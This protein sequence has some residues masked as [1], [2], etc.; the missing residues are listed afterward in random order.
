MT[1]AIITITG[2]HCASCVAKIESAL[3][4]NLGISKAK[5]NFASEKAYVEYNPAKATLENLYHAITEAGYTPVKN[6]EASI[7]IEKELES[8]TQ[9]LS[10]GLQRPGV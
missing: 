5:V 9:L 6:E 1:K 3:K 2:M 4:K 8:K 10:Y 7:D